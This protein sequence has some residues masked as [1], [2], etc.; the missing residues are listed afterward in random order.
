M[1]AYVR[2]DIDILARI[3]DP[4]CVAASSSANELKGDGQVVMLPP[5]GISR[6]SALVKAPAT[7]VRRR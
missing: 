6:Q 1:S 7:S 3:D 4:W 5:A 2:S